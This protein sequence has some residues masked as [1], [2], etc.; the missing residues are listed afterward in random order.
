MVIGPRGTRMGRGRGRS[1]PPP[2]MATRLTPGPG[3]G[4]GPGKGSADVETADVAPSWMSSVLKSSDDDDDD[5]AQ[6]VPVSRSTAALQEKPA[7]LMEA[8]TSL[9]PW[10]KPYKAKPKEHSDGGDQ[11]TAGK[12]RTPSLGSGMPKWGQ[13]A[14]VPAVKEAKTP[15]S[16]IS[17]IRPVEWTFLV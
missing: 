6:P 5:F 11:A 12:Q 9:P 8:S 7:S 13:K 1:P 3:A 16:A 14:N 10:A 2:G 4:A 15:R 17:V